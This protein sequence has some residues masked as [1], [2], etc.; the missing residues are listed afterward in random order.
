MMNSGFGLPQVTAL[1]LCGLSG[2]LYLF[3]IAA[4]LG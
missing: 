1:W 3:N 2:P 4:L